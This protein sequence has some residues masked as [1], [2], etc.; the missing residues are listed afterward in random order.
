[1][2]IIE[3]EIKYLHSDI[4]RY[5]ILRGIY[6]SSDR[7]GHGYP[8]CKIQS[9]CY[10]RSHRL[11]FSAYHQLQAYCQWRSS[12]VLRIYVSL[13]ATFQVSTV[14]EGELSNPAPE[15][16]HGWTLERVAGRYLEEIWYQSIL[17]VWG[18]LRQPL[19]T[20][21]DSTVERGRTCYVP[22]FAQHRKHKPGASFDCRALLVV[23]LFHI[24]LFTFLCI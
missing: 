4:Q 1:M 6:Q 21:V 19:V 3:L 2:R 20:V 15:I 7:V 16:F 10:R 5:N 18:Q 22:A 23:W 24:C 17:E 9:V 12:V 8:Y 14:G 11:Q 13:F